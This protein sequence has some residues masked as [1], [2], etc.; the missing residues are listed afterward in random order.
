MVANALNRCYDSHA[1][2][3]VRMLIGIDILGL[4]LSAS[5][6]LWKSQIDELNERDIAESCYHTLSP[7]ASNVRRQ[8]SFRLEIFGHDSL[9]EAQG[10]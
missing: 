10:E 6:R 9:S 7:I 3:S 4:I 2:Q 8:Y 5:M 1:A